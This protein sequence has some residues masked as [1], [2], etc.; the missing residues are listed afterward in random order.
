MGRNYQKSVAGRLVAA[1]RLYRSRAGAMLGP[2]GLHAG[3]EGVL[4]ALA[5]SDGQAMSELAGAL[6]VQPPTVTKMVARLSA[7]GYVERRASEAD[8]RQ[9]RVFLTKAGTAL[10]ESLDNLLV[11]LE[12]QSLEGI[13]EKDRKTLRKLLR[14]IARN[15]GDEADNPADS[16]PDGPD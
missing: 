8:G 5:L 7:Q 13:S 16:D 1:T 9:A 11:E 15:L 10:L 6:G 2:M 14:K 3:Q 4:N 12:E